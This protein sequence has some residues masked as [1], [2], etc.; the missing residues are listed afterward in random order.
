MPL[1]ESPVITS[2][3]VDWSSAT[4]RPCKSILL[5]NGWAYLQDGRYT[6]AAPL[7]I[8]DGA[9]TQITFLLSNL[10]YADSSN[11]TLNYNQSNNRFYPTENKSCYLVNLRFKV[12]PSAN[13]GHIDITIES[14][15][16][17]FNPLIGHTLTFAKASGDE[18]FFSVSGQ[19]FISPDVIT[20]GVTAYITASGTDVS[21]YD[22]S[23]LAQKTYIP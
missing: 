6:V 13:S 16:V 11:L 23:I 2:Y 3:M 5:Q 20:N 4:E 8:A 14:P 22:Y 9:K 12:K 7:V 19:I 10:A 18:Q 21:I 1:F 15:G 17:S